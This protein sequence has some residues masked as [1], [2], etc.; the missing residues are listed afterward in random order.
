[1]YSV[2]RIDR[3]LV[4]ERL[5]ELVRGRRLAIVFGS[6][7]RGEEARDVDILVDGRDV[8]DAAKLAAVAEEVLGVRVDV[9]PAELAHPCLVVEAVRSGVVLAADDEYLDELYYRSVGQCQDVLI[10]LRESASAQP[11]S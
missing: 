2:R 3:E 5:R 1:M 6:L 4:V 10:K 7:A 9:V 8:I 11:T